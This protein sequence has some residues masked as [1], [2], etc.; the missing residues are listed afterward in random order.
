MF[1]IVALLVGGDVSGRV[2]ALDACGDNLL[3]TRFA[4]VNYQGQSFICEF[5]VV[6]FMDRALRRTRALRCNAQQ[7]R[8][9]TK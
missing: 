3:R 6:F 4:A 2:T 9:D 1:R 7:L 8:Y 5:G